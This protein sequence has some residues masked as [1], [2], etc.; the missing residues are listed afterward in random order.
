[1]RG[2]SIMSDE[3]R[4]Y[5]TGAEIG[6]DVHH[7][8]HGPLRSMADKNGL[9]CYLRHDIHM[10]LHDHARGFEDLDSLLKRECQTKFEEQHT[11]D[12]WM[13]LVHRNYL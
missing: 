9:W 1:M 12:E 7:V 5:V 13:L 6:L 10:K 11:R 2:K 4:C 3:R 8:I